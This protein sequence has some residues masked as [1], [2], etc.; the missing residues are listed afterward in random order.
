MINLLVTPRVKTKPNRP[1]WIWV[2][3][4][5]AWAIIVTRTFFIQNYRI[6]QNGMF[7]SLPAGS[8]PFVWKRAY[9]SESDVRRGDI[10]VFQREE[11]GQKYIY[12]WRVIGLPG[13]KVEASGEA[14]TIN[15]RAPARERLRETNGLTIFRETIDTASYE[16]AVDP[17]PRQRPPDASI[18]VPP[19]HFFVM[20]DNRLNAV[21]S[22]Y[23]GPISFRSIIGRKL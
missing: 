22:R 14:L 21:D 12:V 11:N 16:I 18:T 10:V 9:A 13:E 23:L 8:R 17:Q 3:V 19:G 20:G 4:A 6:P 2:V 15:G 1:I 5:A 7:P